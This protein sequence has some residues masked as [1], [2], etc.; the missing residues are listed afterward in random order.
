MSD[1]IKIVFKNGQADYVDPVVERFERDGTLYIHNGA[2]MY[3][4]PLS[5]IAYTEDYEVRGK[6]QPE[7]TP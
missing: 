2:Y 5:K 4:F 3:D 6:A 1:G 7:A